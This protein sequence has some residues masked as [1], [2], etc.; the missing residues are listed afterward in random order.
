MYYMND[1]LKLC[2]QNNIH[3]FKVSFSSDTIDKSIKFDDIDDFFA[4][5]KLSDIKQVYVMQ[6]DIDV[7]DYL[8]TEDVVESVLG[9][10]GN[11][12]IFDCIGG[13]ID[14][15]NEK[16]SELKTDYPLMIL[17]GCAYEGQMFFLCFQNQTLMNGK[18]LIE[19]EEV[20]QE[21][22]I[23]NEKS[24]KERQENRHKLIEEQKE[25]LKEYI[26]ND[27]EFYLSTNQHLR[28]SYTEN[29]FR[30][31]IGKKYVELKDFWS[32]PYGLLS[33]GAFDFIEMLWR[34]FGKT[35]K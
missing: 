27:K 11:D 26:L 10:Y 29:L 5:C 28:Y 17:V 8:I 19:P 33:K 22:I 12:D 9:R 14:E 15:Y 6:L 24:I 1:V 34:E 7:E 3:A 25:Q 4:F 13:D 30:K 2:D 20:L 21:M 35:K 32:T 31:K 16:V 23:D 18:E